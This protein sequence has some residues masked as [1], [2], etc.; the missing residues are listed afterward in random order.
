MSAKYLQKKGSVWYFRRRVKAGCE[1]LHRDAR[2]KP[3][4]V[5]F[6]SLKRPRTRE[7]AKRA[8]SQARMQDALWSNH[9][10]GTADATN[11]KAALGRLEAVTPL[12]VRVSTI[13]DDFHVSHKH[14]LRHKPEIPGSG[15][16]G[17]SKGGPVQGAICP[18]GMTGGPRCSGEVWTA[19]PSF[20]YRPEP[21]GPGRWHIGYRA[22]RFQGRNGP[23]VQ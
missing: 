6:F 11:P 9:L 15:P 21:D 1:G 14:M 4:S 12:A 16:S 18:N 22:V 10:K 23:A 2:G 7:T 3:Q 20:W 5:L 13:R 8:D 19:I 17:R